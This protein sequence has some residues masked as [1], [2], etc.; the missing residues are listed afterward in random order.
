[1]SVI[2]VEK[3]KNYTVM[4][5]YHLRDTRLTLKAKGLLSLILSLPEDWDYTIPGLAALSRDGKDAVRSCLEELGGA[6]YIRR[7]RKR[8]ENG[9]YGG[10][11]YVVHERPQAGEAPPSSENPTMAEPSSEN[12]AMDEPSPENPTLEKP[13]L[14]NPTEQNTKIQST[15]SNNIIPPVSPGGGKQKK[16]AHDHEAYR[17]AAYLDKQICERLPGRRGSDEAALQRWAAD[18]EKCRRIDG[19]DW[20]TIMDVLLFSQRDRFWQCN[21]LS[22]RKFR[23]KFDMLLMKLRNEGGGGAR[24]APAARSRVLERG[25]VREI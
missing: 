10:N 3:T 4:A 13:T 14:E 24:D 21:I 9:T 1:M 2:R 22:G 20:K 8:G 18:F 19:Y 12:P 23:T 11:E 15:E 16:F 7:G 5:N 6:G 25:G 17:C